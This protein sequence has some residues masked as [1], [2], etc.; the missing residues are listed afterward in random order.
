MG[1]RREPL[2]RLIQMF[3]IKNLLGVMNVSFLCL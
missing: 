1:K 2:R 3:D